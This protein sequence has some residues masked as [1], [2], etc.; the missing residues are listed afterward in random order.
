MQ[1]LDRPAFV[2][3]AIY[4]CYPETRYNVVAY[5]IDEAGRIRW[6]TD[7]GMNG[8]GNKAFQCTEVALDNWTN[9]VPVSM[10]ECGT[11]ELFDLLDGTRRVQ[12]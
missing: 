1:L 3:N 9:Y 7:Y 12:T 10:F 5:G 6:A 11:L 2:L 4:D 8:D